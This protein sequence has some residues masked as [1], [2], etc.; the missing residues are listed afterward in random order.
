MRYYQAV[1]GVLVFLL[2]VGA[3]CAVLLS[4]SRENEET[5]TLSQ[6]LEPVAIPARAEEEGLFGNL[7]LESEEQISLEQAYLWINGEKC[8]DFAQGSLTVRVYP[9][10]VIQLDTLA[11]GRTLFFSIQAVSSSI[12]MDYLSSAITCFAEIVTVGVIIFR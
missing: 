11:Y 1:Q 5:P 12:D 7:Y 10:D 3:A 9:G 2:L 6:D 4:F 8:G